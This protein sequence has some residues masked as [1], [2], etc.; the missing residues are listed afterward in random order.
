LVGSE[1]KD[2]HEARYRGYR[3]CLT[4]QRWRQFGL[5]E[6]YQSAVNRSYVYSA[7][8]RRGQICANQVIPVVGAEFADFNRSLVRI[9]DAQPPGTDVDE[10]PI[11]HQLPATRILGYM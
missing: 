1:V 3:G 6:I 10:V 4:V 8:L 9:A 5:D 7:L 11:Q 2:K